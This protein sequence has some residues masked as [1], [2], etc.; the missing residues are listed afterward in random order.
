MVVWVVVQLKRN[1]VRVKHMCV[2]RTFVKTIIINYALWFEVVGHFVT[3][4]IIESFWPLHKLHR[5]NLK[6]G[7]NIKK[8]YSNQSY[9]LELFV[10]K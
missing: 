10:T 7:H 4:I 2:S 9:D 1:E 6:K 3:S 5:H 8:L